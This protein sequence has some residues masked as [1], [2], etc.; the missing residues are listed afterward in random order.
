M[1]KGLILIF[2]LAAVCVKGQ[3]PRK[4][5]TRF[6]GSGHDIGY[7]VIQTLNG[8][9]AVTGSTGSFGNGNTDA[10]LALVDSM[11]WVRWEKSY[12]GF[13]NDI[14]RSIIQLADSGFVITGYTNSFGSGGYD[15]LVVRTDKAGTLIW[16]KAF[17]GL[18][19][20]FGYCV[21]TSPGGDSLIV[22]GSTYSYG[23]G[24]MDGYILKIDL[25][26]VLQWQDTYGGPEDDEF[27][28]FVVT[29]TNHYA[30]AGT[31][32]SM[33]DLNGD[34]WLVKTGLAADSVFSIKHGD[35]KK[36]FIN[37]I[38]EGV[39]GDFVMAGAT[40]I[41]GRDTTWGYLL[42]LDQ[43]GNFSYENN[44]PRS[45]KFKDYQLTCVTRA[46]NS[47]Y[48]Y[49]YKTFEAPVGFK[50]EPL[51]MDITGMW[52]SVVNTYG[53]TS[54][55]EIF[56]ICRTKDKGFIAVGYTNGFSLSPNDGFLNDVFLVKMDSTLFNSKNYVGVPTFAKTS[57]DLFIYP[58][59][60][61]ELINISCEKSLLNNSTMYVTNMAG[62]KLEVTFI[63]PNQ[64][65][66][67]SF[68][69]GI[70]FVTFMKDGY[71]RSFKVV[72]TD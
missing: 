52:P 31:T 7:G 4:F 47:N 33:G 22:A 55:E 62:Q 3:A 35:N 68:A 9:Y 6:G 46:N 38:V 67:K 71:S 49:V 65:S 61:N 59:I 44:F 54:D 18:D 15:V 20:D 24:K 50:L 45:E 8:Q 28:S 37:D 5:F 40:D 27:K 13:N 57:E 14:G 34:C 19:W 2:F 26:G 36:Q 1:K 64:I 32:K 23:Y 42:S 17:G 21:K 51:F 39:S 72:K 53:S 56:D 10:F 29:S 48:I 70:Y 16:Q 58:T 69:A 43:N 12:G 11:G 60:T 25:N 30:F 66:I 63:Q 41:A